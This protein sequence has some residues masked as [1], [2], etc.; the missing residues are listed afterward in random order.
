MS[1]RD[2]RLEILQKVARGEL[3]IEDS[4]HLL[5]KMELQADQ[6]E[7]GN[8]ENDY[9]HNVIEPGRSDLDSTRWKKWWLIPFGIFTILTILAGS[10]TASSYLHNKF[11]FGFWISLIFLFICLFGMILSIMSQ[12]APWIHIRVTQKPGKHSGVVNL[13]FPLPL[14]LAGWAINNFSWAM[15]EK[16]RDKS[17][18]EAFTAFES[19][20]SHGEPFHVLVDEEDGDHVEIFI[21]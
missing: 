17:I 21:G 9:T 8:V 18:T 11:S 12:H 14:R 15:P 20:V 4:A 7:N 6:S 2:S 3:S 16:F 19:S 13:S 10:L 1:E 5:K